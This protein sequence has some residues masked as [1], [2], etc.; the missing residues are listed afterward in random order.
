MKGIPSLQIQTTPRQMQLPKLRGDLAIDQYPSRA[1]YNLQTVIDT[2][3]D[4]AQRGYQTA[5][6]TIG[7]IAADGDAVANRQ[8]TVA[9]QAV[10]AAQPIPASVDLVSIARPSIQYNVSRQPGEFQPAQVTID[11]KA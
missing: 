10:A 2:T 6:A 4:D 3:R 5:L 9:A 8:S 11:I 1:S 7:R